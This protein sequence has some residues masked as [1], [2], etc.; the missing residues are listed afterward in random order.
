MYLLEYFNTKTGLLSNPYF[1]RVFPDLNFLYNMILPII[2]H[3]DFIPQ[4]H[5]D[6]IIF[7]VFPW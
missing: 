4:L 7:S 5:W 2:L 3:Y 6:F 1:E